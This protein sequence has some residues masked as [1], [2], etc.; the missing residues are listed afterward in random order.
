MD[1][2][3]DSSYPLPVTEAPQATAIWRY[4]SLGRFIALLADR[5]LY[6]ARP[7]AFGDQ[8]EAAIGPE[9]RR[10]DWLEGCRR[11]FREVLQEARTAGKLDTTTVIEDE[12]QRLLGEWVHL[13]R[14]LP[15]N[16]Y[17]SC[18]HEGEHESEAMWRLHTKD[19]SEGVAI[20]STCERLRQ[21]ISGPQGLR[22][23]RVLYG[24]YD[25]GPTHPMVRFFK[26]RIS[27]EHEREIRAAFIAL[28][29]QPRKEPGKLVPVDLEVLIQDVVVS[30]FAPDWL[31]PTVSV[32]LERFETKLQVRR[33][34]LSARSFRY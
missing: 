4:L 21:A 34:S 30:P 2:T 8:F 13:N 25:S 18:W 15:L 7:E 11:M 3:A 5:A 29:D 6:F 27:F 32:L 20:R 17:L 19:S 26:K 33:S 9:E 28:D 24:E 22:I 10:E 16:T 12:V 31:L 14:V 1:V 23:A